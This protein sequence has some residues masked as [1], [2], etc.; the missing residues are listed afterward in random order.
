[1]PFAGNNSC[2]GQGCINIQHLGFS[3][4]KI[5]K[6]E[7]GPH[8]EEEQPAEEEPRRVWRQDCGQGVGHL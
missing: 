8:G 2:G 6:E 5:I 7:A 3:K 1:M 4:S